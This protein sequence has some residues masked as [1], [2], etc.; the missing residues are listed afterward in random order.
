M[1]FVIGLAA[2]SLPLCR[3]CVLSPPLQPQPPPPTVNPRLLHLFYTCPSPHGYLAPSSTA[4]S[5]RPLPCTNPTSKPGLQLCN[6]N[7][8]SLS[9]CES[10]PSRQRQ[11]HARHP[12]GPLR[13]L[14]STGFLTGLDV[15]LSCGRCTRRVRLLHA[16]HNKSLSCGHRMRHEPGLQSLYNTRACPAV[17][18]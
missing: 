4:A 18:A 17:T 12:G 13:L 7:L 3:S 9:F 10:S 16:L 2:T 14:L 8:T 11:G 15:S 5:V 6:I 1:C